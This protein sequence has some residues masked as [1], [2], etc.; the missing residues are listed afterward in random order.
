MTRE[1][2]LLGFV[3]TVNENSPGTSFSSHLKM[4]MLSLICSRKKKIYISYVLRLKR[5]KDH[6]TMVVSYYSFAEKAFT[7]DP[8]EVSVRTDVAFSP[9]FSW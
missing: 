7:R 9:L 3:G 1:V 6:L 2:S 4:S 8:T 5:G